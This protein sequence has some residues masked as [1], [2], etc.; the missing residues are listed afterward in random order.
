MLSCLNVSLTPRLHNREIFSISEAQRTE[1]VDEPNLGCDSR[2]SRTYL[3]NLG[4]FCQ[5]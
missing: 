3:E 2:S 5:K 4:R 1:A